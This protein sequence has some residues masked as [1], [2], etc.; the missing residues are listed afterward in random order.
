MFTVSLTGVTVT[1][2][3]TS[4]TGLPSPSQVNASAA[5]AGRCLTRA[6]RASCV[7]TARTAGTSAWGTP[8]ES[9]TS[10]S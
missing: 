8:K 6:S 4:S 10:S 1:A 2:A 3:R 9:S 7:F 5:S